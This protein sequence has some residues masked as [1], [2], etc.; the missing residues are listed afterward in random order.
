MQPLTTEER[1]FLALAIQGLCMR[2]GPDT[3]VT[4]AR[5]A[6]KLG[7]LE[8]LKGMLEMWLAY[9]KP[10]GHCARCNQPLDNVSPGFSV[11]A[12]GATVCANCLRPDEEL[13]RARGI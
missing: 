8:E 12:G 9:A 6:G 7:L 11:V 10:I 1:Q 13:L 2:H 5:L 4:A 3:F